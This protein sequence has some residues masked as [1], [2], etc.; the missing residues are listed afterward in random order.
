MHL[1]SK[2][3]SVIDFTKQGQHTKGQAASGLIMVERKGYNDLVKTVNAFQLVPCVN[4]QCTK[5]A[6]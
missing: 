2:S 6:L 3:A 5:Q 1:G 4:H